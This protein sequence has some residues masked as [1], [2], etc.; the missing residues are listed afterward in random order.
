MRLRCAVFLAAL[1]VA[2]S[3]HAEPAVAPSVLP[4]LVVLAGA[5]VVTT[6]AF[7]VGRGYARRTG[8]SATKVVAIA[9]GLAL[10][11]YGVL[12]APIAFALTAILASGRTF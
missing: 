9:I 5:A 10:L 4:I 7:L 6:V 11:A 12:G 1:L 3:A 2:P 8:R